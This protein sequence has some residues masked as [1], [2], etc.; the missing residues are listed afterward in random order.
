M[1]EAPTRDTIE[2]RRIAEGTF[3]DFKREVDLDKKYPGGAKSAKERFIDDVVA[4]LNGE[5]GHLI[6]GVEEADGVWD[7]FVPMSGD[8]EKICNRYLQVIQSTIVPLPTKVNIVPIDVP[9][10]FVLDVQVP[11]HWRKPYQNAMSGAFYVRAGAR[12]RVLTVP[13]IREHFADFERMETDLTRLFD[14]FRRDLLAEDNLSSVKLLSPGPMGSLSFRSDNEDAG[15]RLLFGILP[16]QHY[17]RSRP[18]YDPSKLSQ[19]AVAAFNGGWY[20]RLRGCGGG[21]EAAST[22]ERLFVATDWHI[23]GWVKHPFDFTRERPDMA[24]F[25]ENLGRFI[26]SISDFLLEARVVGPFAITLAIEN[27]DEMEEWP[28]PGMANEVGDSRPSVMESLADPRLID[29][30]VAQVRSVLYG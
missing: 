14:V 27:L 10:G 2:S 11:P 5:G 13:E 15:P 21:F 24:A 23:L 17:D 26:A 8:R 22:H 19:P 9:G 25:R 12:N 3:Y 7:K 29:D 18:R 1:T 6:I 20:P 28:R 30:F 4:F 16:R